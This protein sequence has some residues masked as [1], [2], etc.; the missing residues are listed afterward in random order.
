MPRFALLLGL[1]V[2]AFA[3]DP[4]P[5][6]FAGNARA[7]VLVFARTDCP[8]T[9]RY[10]PEL[11]RIAAGFSRGVEFWMVYPDSAETAAAIEKHIAEFH[12]PGRWT[13]DPE[14]AL[15]RRAEA[16]VAPQ[17]AVFDAAGK[18]V[19]SGRIDDRYVDFG[20]FRPAPTV[21]DLE[22]AI[23]AALAG[24]PATPARTRATGCFL[25]DVK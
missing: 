22:N 2:C 11:R 4:Q 5:D 14:H 15:V 9:N 12:F 3:S 21:H 17:A 23:A 16:T 13:R 10:A 24:R 18:L 1:A 8:I 19:Y 20:K 6:P 7:R 25:A